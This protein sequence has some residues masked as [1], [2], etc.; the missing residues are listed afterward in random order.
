MPLNI[1]LFHLFKSLFSQ[2][3]VYD[4]YL[5]MSCRDEPCFTFRRSQVDTLF[6]HKSE[7]LSKLFRRRR[8]KLVHTLFTFISKVYSKCTFQR[9]TVIVTPAFFSGHDSISFQFCTELFVKENDHNPSGC[10]STS[11]QAIPAA[12][13]S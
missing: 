7:E 2:L 11:K 10:R 8:Q 12:I 9:L 1:P 13:L 3:R 4:R 5:L 6:Q